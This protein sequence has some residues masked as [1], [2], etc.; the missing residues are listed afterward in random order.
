MKW[1]MKIKI[2]TIEFKK[3]IMRNINLT[4]NNHN[5]NNK[6]IKKTLIMSYMIIIK[7]KF[8]KSQFNWDF[9]M[10]K[11]ILMI[12]KMILIFIRNNLQSL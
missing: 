8:P 10:K 1:I 11:K 9:T 5:N 7:K 2:L 4:F 3:K 12:G 6:N